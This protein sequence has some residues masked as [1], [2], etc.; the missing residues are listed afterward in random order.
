MAR[1]SAVGQS[2]K[3]PFRFNE[4]HNRLSQGVKDLIELYNL[5]DPH[6]QSFILK[7]KDLLKLAT[8]REYYYEENEGTYKYAFQE[9]DLWDGSD[10]ISTET[11]VVDPDITIDPN[12]LSIFK[13]IMSSLQQNIAN[14]TIHHFYPQTWIDTVKTNVEPV[15]MIE[16]AII[17]E[18]FINANAGQAVQKQTPQSGCILHYTQASKREPR[19]RPRFKSYS[20]PYRVYEV[21]SGTDFGK[22]LLNSESTTPYVRTPAPRKLHEH[23]YKRG[24]FVQIPAIPLRRCKSF[25]EIVRSFLIHYH[26]AFGT[27]ERIKVCKQCNSLFV[28]KRLGAREFCNFACRGQYSQESD[29]D[30]YRCR[31]KRNNWI[32]FQCPQIKGQIT[33]LLAPPIDITKYYNIK[34]FKP[35]PDTVLKS[36][37][38]T[39]NLY[40]TPRRDCPILMEKNKE[41][42]TVKEKLSVA[43]KKKGKERTQILNELESFLKSSR[44]YRD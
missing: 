12:Q 1:D 7:M 15:S 35:V 22:L 2:A 31:N 5:Q 19:S 17:P 27:F 38:K 16:D 29:P 37:C 10:W 20:I 14:D 33:E 4:I 43:F 8:G 26:L 40:K 42:F 21:G 24:L 25:I 34:T 36:D 6:D 3:E 39:C 9:D 41:T 11:P 30:K 18:K 13:D 28:E 23:L 32:R 44:R